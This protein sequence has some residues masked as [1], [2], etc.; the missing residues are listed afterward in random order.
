MGCADPPSK[1]GRR[2][3]SVSSRVGSKLPLPRYADVQFHIP[4]THR[5]DAGFVFSPGRQNRSSFVMG[6]TS[7]A[8]CRRRKGP[9]N[10]GRTMGSKAWN[11]NRG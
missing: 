9:G 4:M 11:K 3:P 10:R 5:D 1:G 6:H 7:R 2:T 8:P